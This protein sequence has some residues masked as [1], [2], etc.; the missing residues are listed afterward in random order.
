MATGLNQDL[1]KRYIESRD[2]EIDRLLSQYGTSLAETREMY[3]QLMTAIEERRRATFPTQPLFFDAAQLAE[4]GL[5]LDEG[6]MM[7]FTP[8]EEGYG[9]SYITPEKWEIREGDLYVSPTGE[10]YTRADLEALLAYPGGTIPDQLSFI[11]DTLS[12]EDLT[13]TGRQF[14]EEYRAGGGTLSVAEWV[15]L[16]E[17]EQLETEQIFGRVFP[18]RDI[19]ELWRYIEERPE[20]FL[21]ELAELGRTPDTEALLRALAPEITEADIAS[22]FITPE[23][24]LTIDWGGFYT[25]NVT[26]ILAGVEQRVTEGQFRESVTTYALPIMEML[27]PDKTLQETID[28]AY[29]APHAFL[30]DLKAY[31]KGRPGLVGAWDVARNIIKALDP[32]IP[33]MDIYSWWRPDLHEPMSFV[34]LPTHVGFDEAMQRTLFHTAYDGDTLVELLPNIEGVVAPKL[35]FQFSST[36]NDFLVYHEGEVV[37]RVDIE[38]GD[39]ELDDRFLR[40]TRNMYLKAYAPH[41]SVTT[42]TGITGITGLP[43]SVSDWLFRK[44]VVGDKMLPAPAEVMA[45][46][47][48]VGAVAMMT[49]QGIQAL[50]QVLQMPIG[51]VLPRAL[52]PAKIAEVRPLAS[53]FAHVP[54]RIAKFLHIPQP[55]KMIVP[56]E[57]GKLLEV[58]IVDGKPVPIYAPAQ[59][60]YLTPSE[61][62]IYK[63][64]VQTAGYQETYQ[65]FVDKGMPTG[66]IPA[67]VE[68]RWNSSLGVHEKVVTAAKQSTF[69]Q[70]TNE[71]FRS[72]LAEYHANQLATRI[73][74]TELA[75]Q[76]LRAT[77]QVNAAQAKQQELAALRMMEGAMRDEAQGIMNTLKTIMDAQLRGEH[78]DRTAVR[79]AGLLTTGREPVT[80][81]TP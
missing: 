49:Y 38:T 50:W 32:T 29:T 35:N 57:K 54:S 15:R 40:D 73:K 13:E 76:H 17:Q 4:M 8:Q 80:P 52:V 31:M 26:S 44:K 41:V 53:L 5:R 77:N 1:L 24:M 42:I 74:D 46:V 3:P 2:I 59:P 36:T 48:M 11:P 7:K 58:K 71:M 23:E 72:Y 68:M 20:E 12:L 70:V 6:W 45:V 39:I 22:L 34:L 33:D 10:E 79:I 18:D 65:A 25:D 21:L 69:Q 60:R 51:Q 75:L 9:I 56:G 43:Q 28:Y 81:P 66:T 27:Y 55:G 19:E 63:K 67:K 14:Y 78:P 62:N 61:L 47:A 30:A 16:R 37:G 64:F